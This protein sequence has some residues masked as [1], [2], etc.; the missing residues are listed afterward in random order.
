MI[1]AEL[2]SLY[3]SLCA[4]RTAVEHVTVQQGPPDCGFDSKCASLSWLHNIFNIPN[5]ALTCSSLHL[6]EW[7]PASYLQSLESDS[8]RHVVALHA[9]ELGQAVST[10]FRV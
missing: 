6:R 9:L 8:M 5:P 1:M 10:R 7:G 4:R 2:R 3:V